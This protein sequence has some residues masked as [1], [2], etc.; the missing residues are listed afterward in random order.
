MSVDPIAIPLRT[1]SQILSTQEA[2]DRMRA[3]DILAGLKSASKTTPSDE[4]PIAPKHSQVIYSHGDAA[5]P[6]NWRSV[7]YKAGMVLAAITIV[8]IGYKMVSTASA[9]PPPVAPGPL[10]ALSAKSTPAPEISHEV[11]RIEAPAPAKPVSL[12]KASEVPT[13][14]STMQT[15]GDGIRMLHVHEGYRLKSYPDI[16]GVWTIGYGHTGFLLDGRPIG[17][18]MTITNEEAEALFINDINRHVDGFKRLLPGVSLTQSQFDALTD[19]VFNKGVEAFEKSDLRKELLRGNFLAAS[20]EFLRWVYITK[21]VDGKMVAEEVPHL[22]QR[23]ATHK[24]LFHDGFSKE[25]I[26]IMDAHRLKLESMDLAVA[27][28][29]Q[30][31][32]PVAVGSNVGEMVLALDRSSKRASGH[33]QALERRAFENDKYVAAM[34]GEA[35]RLT[36]KARELPGAHDKHVSQSRADE[37]LEYNQKIGVAAY[38]IRTKSTQSDEDR[39]AHRYYSDLAVVAKLASQAL[40]EYTRIASQPIRTEADQA[41]I[42]SLQEKIEDAR[43]HLSQFS[44]RYSNAPEGGAIKIVLNSDMIDRLTDSLLNADRTIEKNI[45]RYANAQR[46]VPATTEARV[47]AVA[48]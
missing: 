15:S 19:F 35:K 1:R 20:E 37:I 39:S 28:T 18:N 11:V 16:K 10:A 7:A 27:R 32:A 14:I 12:A 30:G 21:K 3:F 25:T 44:D 31:L 23:A 22:A 4:A 42:A 17:P 24:K 47:R 6:S 46:E 48:K 13:D 40:G 2:C 33:A 9:P 8:A 43:V 34:T 41:R 26:K 29:S 45:V 38:V 36:K 5:K